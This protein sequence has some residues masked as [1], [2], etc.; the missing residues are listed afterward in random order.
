MVSRSF[1]SF[2]SILIFQ[3]LLPFFNGQM[4]NNLASP[5]SRA[6]KSQG[7]T[8]SHSSRSFDG[9]IAL[10]II[11]PATQCIEQGF[12]SNRVYLVKLV[13]GE[14]KLSFFFFCRKKWGAVPQNWKHESAR[15]F[16]DVRLF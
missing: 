10:G 14:T 9:H 16:K 4:V 1:G 7:R 11:P 12:F 15:N 13:S 3:K 6:A 5:Q 8:F 2:G